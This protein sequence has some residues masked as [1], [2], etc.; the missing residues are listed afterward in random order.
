MAIPA[1]HSYTLYLKKLRGMPL[2][3]D[4]VQGDLFG[5]AHIPHAAAAAAFIKHRKNNLK[6]SATALNNFLDCRLKFYYENLAQLGA[7]KNAATVFGWAV[8]LALEAA[9]RYRHRPDT[10]VHTGNAFR[11]HMHSHK[12]FFTNE[13]FAARLQDGAEIIG[14]YL[15]TPPPETK[16]EAAHAEIYLTAR[17][18]GIPLCGVVDKL[19]V[20]QNLVTITDYKTGRSPA[21]IASMQAPNPAAPQGGKYWRQAIFYKILADAQ[22][23]HWVTDKVHFHFLETVTGLDPVVEIDAT[24]ASANTVWQQVR[25]AAGP[26]SDNLIFSGCGNDLCPYCLLANEDALLPQIRQAIT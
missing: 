2:P 7:G 1:L 20:H 13:Q 14:R 26:I 24:E 12:N 3:A 4:A 21:N 19:E 23:N 6:L 11:T 5:N 18:Q 17:L 10:E 22:P 25:Q 8:H 9:F 15:S 16:P